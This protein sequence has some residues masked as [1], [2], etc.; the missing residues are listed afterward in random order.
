MALRLIF[1]SFII[2]CWSNA[3]QHLH[4]TPES[5]V[6]EG[7]KS[8][9]VDVPNEV[10]VYYTING[11]KPTIESRQLTKGNLSIDRNTAFRFLIISDK[12]TLEQSKTYIIDRAHNLPVFSLITDSM[13]LFDPIKGIY[14]KGP[15]ASDEEPYKG[16]N[17]W[18]GWERPIRVAYIN[19]QNEQ[20]I[21]QASGVQ[22]FGGFSMAMPQKSFGLYARKEYGSNRFEYP[23][24]K[25]RPFNEY[26]D[27]VLRN[28]GSDM[29][30]A[31]IRDAYA[32]S[33]VESTGLLV[34]AYQPVAVYING[35]YWGKYNLRE[36]INEH[37][38]E[39]HY[40]YDTDS[41]IIMRHEKSYQ[42]GSTRD[43]KQFW[44]RL[45]QLNLSKK[46]DL[47]Y[48]DRKIDIDNYLLYNAC[49][50]YTGNADAGGNIRYFKHV[51]DTA[52][53]RWIFF[54]VDH[55][56]NIF[57]KYAH[58]KNSVEHFTSENPQDWPHPNWSTLLIRKLLENDSI[59][60]LY[61]QRFCDL[62]NTTFHPAR[63]SGVLDSIV[64]QV[65]Q[66]VIYHRKRWGVK[67]YI[68]EFSLRKLY[69]HV[70]ERPALLFQH[71]QQRFGLGG[72]VQVNINAV[73]GGK[74]R[75]NSLKLT[76]DYSG[77]YFTSVPILIEAIPDFGYEFMG[78]EQT[79]KKKRI[80]D[81]ILS[82][83]F[84]L[85]PIF[86]KKPVSKYLNKILITEID[87]EQDSIYDT[88]YIEL[89]NASNSLVSI[90]GWIITDVKNTYQI[91]EG[92][93]LEPNE[94]VVITEGSARFYDSFRRDCL[95]G[96][97]FGVSKKGEV[98]LLY[99]RDSCFVDKVNTKN[100]KLEKKGF[101][102]A[103]IAVNDSSIYFNKWVQE[104]PSP[105]RENIYFNQMT[106]NKK[107]E[108]K[109]IF[110]LVISGIIFAVLGISLILFNLARR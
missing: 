63:A 73:E 42:H 104:Q 7:L 85:T 41:L 1:F 35:V 47:D 102:W 2:A 8:I 34:Q 98:I 105:G 79:E 9:S 44:S 23:F 36:K 27:L 52:K 66:E 31:H 53:W 100:W 15:N 61:I 38:I 3:Q 17:F 75:L 10:T 94:Y 49:Q 30:G 80:F 89:F 78:W 13:H 50:V 72:M 29:Q 21:D 51:S 88:D 5:G 60:H 45:P 90:G 40:G 107:R 48:V 12:D 70:Q 57:E 92:T 18:K 11:S 46:E 64:E 101:N 81:T 108:E 62:L 99:D 22:M 6:H 69:T 58:R 71:L 86:Q 103:R 95:H 25:N 20:V 106:R 77:N 93:L 24:F 76:D 83:N 54:D 59:K 16:A 19:E 91:P 33:L 84:S 96:L 87:A 39:Q 28:A 82:N 110:W 56:M 32:S 109:I 4:F 65:D 55:S 37:F 43:Y 74:V 26:K 67:N 14:R 68:Y 97:S